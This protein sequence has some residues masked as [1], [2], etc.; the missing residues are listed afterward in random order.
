MLKNTTMN[1]P[2]EL[3]ARV[4]AYAAQNQT[5]MGLLRGLEDVGVIAS[6]DNVIDEMLHPTKPGRRPEDA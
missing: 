1:L 2:D 3:V 6:A 5:T 4:R